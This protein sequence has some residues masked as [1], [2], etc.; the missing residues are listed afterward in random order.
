M[1]CTSGC[2]AKPGTTLGRP[3]WVSSTLGASASAFEASSASGAAKAATVQ[4]SIDS[5]TEHRDRLNMVRLQ[6][7][8]EGA[9]ACVYS[10]SGSLEL[11]SENAISELDAAFFDPTVF[12]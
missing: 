3:S 9:N 4:K 2:V 11:S 8:I 6:E 5:T 10:W 7:S 12:K 1:F